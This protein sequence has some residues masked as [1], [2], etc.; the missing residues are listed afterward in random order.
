[1]ALRQGDMDGEVKESTSFSEQKETKKPFFN[2][3]H[4]IWHERA[5]RKNQNKKVFLCGLQ[6][7]AA[8]TSHANGSVIKVL[9]TMYLAKW[10]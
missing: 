3:G 9:V 7:E 10:F 4:G 8:T 5:T 6:V 2:L 1:M